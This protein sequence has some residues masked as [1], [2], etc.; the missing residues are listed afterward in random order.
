MDMAIM[1]IKWVFSLEYL[2]TN[3][4]SRKDDLSYNTELEYRQISAFFIYDLGSKL[5]LYLLK[6][7]NFVDYLI[8]TFNT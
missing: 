5:K 8:Y 4:P 2:K 3:T 7:Y 1:P 6:I